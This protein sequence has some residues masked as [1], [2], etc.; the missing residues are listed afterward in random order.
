AGLTSHVLMVGTFD[1]FELWKPERFQ[2]AGGY[3]RDG[4][5]EAAQYVGF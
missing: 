1:R 4:L 2:E 5:L 3:D